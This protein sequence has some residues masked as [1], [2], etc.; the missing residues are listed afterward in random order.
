MSIPPGN[1]W[2]KT[3]YQRI[4][5]EKA[6]TNFNLCFLLMIPSFALIL[7]CYEETGYI[8]ENSKRDNPMPHI[9]QRYLKLQSNWEAILQEKK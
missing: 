5:Q 7:D 9:L 2:L 8:Q 6:P 3:G 4:S 1:S